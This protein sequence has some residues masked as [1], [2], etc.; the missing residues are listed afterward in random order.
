MPIILSLVSE[1]REQFFVHAFAQ[2][3][4][5]F[6]AG[7]RTRTVDQWVNSISPRKKILPLVHC[8]TELSYAGAGPS[9]VELNNIVSGARFLPLLLYVVFP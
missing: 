1:V 3:K 7:E 5:L 6:G 8:S 9:S 2:A 4:G